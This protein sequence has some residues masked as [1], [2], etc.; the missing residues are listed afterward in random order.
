M[1]NTGGRNISVITV[2]ENIKFTYVLSKRQRLGIES[3]LL[4]AIY[5]TCLKH[6]LNII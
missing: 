2:S 4:Y 3:N 1:G 6:L 5:K